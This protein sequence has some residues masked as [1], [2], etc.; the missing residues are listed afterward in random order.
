MKVIPHVQ[1][2]ATLTEIKTNES[3]KPCNG[4]KFNFSSWFENS[5]IKLI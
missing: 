1:L 5:Q 4:K 2:L 3:L